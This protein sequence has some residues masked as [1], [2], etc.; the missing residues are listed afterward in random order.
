MPIV[1]LALCRATGKAYVGCT[2]RSLPQR[3]DE[4][5]AAAANGSPYKFHQ[6]L[7]SQGFSSF[8]WSVLATCAS[9]AEMYVL[10]RQ[11]VAKYNSYRSGYNSTPGGAGS[12]SD[13]KKSA[14]KLPIRSSRRAT[15]T[16][17]TRR[18]R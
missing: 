4:H 15:S 6:A 14:R 12:P 7:R 2:S 11:Y 3:R 8:T 18:P 1:Y 5:V 9:A 10:E 16:V 17:Y 13:G